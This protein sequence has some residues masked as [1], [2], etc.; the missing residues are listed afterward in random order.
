MAVDQL[1]RPSADLPAAVTSSLAEA[2]AAVASSA[3]DAV[4]AAHVVITLLPAAAAANSVIF[5]DG[6]AGAAPEGCVWADG[7]DRR[8]R[9]ARHP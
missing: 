1:H 5:G 4:T 2:G 3:P 7:H 6:V 8:H 9:D